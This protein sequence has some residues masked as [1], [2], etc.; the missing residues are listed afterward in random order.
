MYASRWQPWLSDALQAADVT[1]AWAAV[2]DNGPNLEVRLPLPDGPVTARYNVKKWDTVKPSTVD[3]LALLSRDD[4]PLLVVADRMSEESVDRLRAGSYSWLSRKPLAS[5]L[6]GELRTART[7][8]AVKDR[9]I[10][11]ERPPTPG[12]GRPARAAGRLAQALFYLGEATQKDLVDETGLSQARISQLLSQWPQGS[13]ITRAGGRPARWRVEDPDRLMSAWLALYVP[14]E[15][16]MSYWYGLESPREQARAALAALKDRGR[17]SGGLAADVLAPWTLPQKVLIY[18]DEGR[19]L[20]AAGLVPS[21]QQA[22]TLELVATRDPTVIPSLRADSFLAAATRTA[23]L[24]LADPLVVLSDLTRSDD[25]DADQ[26]AQR[27]QA[28]LVD[29]WHGFHRG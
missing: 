18:T 16:I 9:Q 7:V 1:V 12:R 26:A 2:G 19:D 15:R 8:Y 17:V 14:E 3:R 29:I 5:G 10:R 23:T 11:D 24:P 27:L 25:L 28:R 22:A 4:V 21:P 13:G 20:S 6:A